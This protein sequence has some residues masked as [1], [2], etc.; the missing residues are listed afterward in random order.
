MWQNSLM[1]AFLILWL[2]WPV[3]ASVTFQ[4]PV[5]MDDGSEEFTVSFRSPNI[6]LVNVST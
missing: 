4:S 3:E 5:R 6:T 1:L 2:G